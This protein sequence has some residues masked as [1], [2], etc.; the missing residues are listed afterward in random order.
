MLG[1][2]VR[3]KS[4]VNVP[5]LEE[6]SVSFRILKNLPLCP[7]IE[8][9]VNSSNTKFIILIKAFHTEVVPTEGEAIFVIIENPSLENVGVGVEISYLTMSPKSVLLYFIIFILVQRDFFYIFT[10]H[11]FPNC[12]A[13][14]Q[15]RDIHGNLSRL[16]YVT[17]MIC[18]SVFRSHKDY[19]LQ[20]LFWLCFRSN[21]RQVVGLSWIL[22]V[23]Y[24]H[25]EPVHVLGTR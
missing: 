12:T 2:I 4:C 14:N 22:V 25:A 3:G 13:D 17:N 10:P 18:Y 23:K 19:T 8:F 16:Y 6:T 21:L 20:K 7:N 9:C 24:M 11:L 5:Y 15:K 1:Y